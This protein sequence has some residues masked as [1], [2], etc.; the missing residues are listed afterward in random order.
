[1][2]KST[3]Y[4]NISLGALLLVA[5]TVFAEPKNIPVSLTM[6]GG[7]QSTTFE[8][9]PD[10]TSTTALTSLVLSDGG[11]NINS[12]VK[13]IAGKIYLDVTP[14]NTDSKWYLVILTANYD[15]CGEECNHLYATDGSGASLQWKYR[16]QLRHGYEEA[17]VGSI[18]PENEWTFS[19]EDLKYLYMW[20][21]PPELPAD[22]Y[23]WAS[24][25]NYTHSG[26]VVLPGTRLQVV[27]GVDLGS[28]FR[29]ATYTG[30]LAF[31][32]YYKE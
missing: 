19:G 28:S 11:Y 18:I 21:M 4:M 7:T 5:G 14:D 2:K 29:A 15:Y 9:Y 16:T 31:E 8:V 24:I 23:E 12:N 20:N 1:V 6:E 22:S 26:Q 32:V 10:E 17:P 25:V 3:K 27:F 13:Y 30:N